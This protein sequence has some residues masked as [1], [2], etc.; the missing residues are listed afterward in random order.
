ML[1]LGTRE[2]RAAA[3]AASSAQ[4]RGLLPL[5][6]GIAMILPAGAGLSPASPGLVALAVGGAGVV[7]L[8][9]VARARRK[10]APPPR[11]RV[12]VPDQ[13]ARGDTTLTGIARRAS[14]EI[15]APLSGEACLL[16]GLHGA[17]G[18]ADVADA[19]GGDFDLELPSGE[20]VMVSLEHAALEVEVAGEPARERRGTPNRPV[21]EELLASRGI[22]HDAPEA[23]LSEHLVRDGDEVT[24]TG[25][26]LG[27][28]VTSLAAGAARSGRA[29]RAPRVIA[30]T[31]ERPLVVRIAGRG[32]A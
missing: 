24:V 20:R 29:A 6:V 30:G 28:T 13:H 8:T 19:D 1:A 5:A 2:G 3:R 22:P 27:G 14:I 11:M 15:S 12:H 9:L 31:E 32:G 25:T 10:A 21:L 18:D 17:A 4:T 23:T 26:F 7:V 16:F